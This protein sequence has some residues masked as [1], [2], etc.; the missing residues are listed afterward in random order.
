MSPYRLI[1]EKICHLSVELEHRAYWAIKQV[2]FDL[3]QVSTQ[4]ALQLN[5]LKELH[6]EAYKNSKIYRAKSKAFHDKHI[7]KKNFHANQKVWLFNSRLRLFPGK[8][9]SRWDGLFIV[10]KAFDHGAVKILNPQN[11]HIFTV[12]GQRLKSY[13]KNEQLSPKESITL[14]D[15]K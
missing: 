14:N 6:N 2:N 3:I 8:L 1:F 10:V 4:R 7:H 13:L 15:P 12:N 9:K 5:G 11:G